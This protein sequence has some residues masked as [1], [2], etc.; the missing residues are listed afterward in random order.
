MLVWIKSMLKVGLIL[1]VHQ[2]IAHQSKTFNLLNKPNNIE[3]VKHNDLS[4]TYDSLNK[5]FIDLTDH[6]KNEKVRNDK[7]ATELSPEPRNALVLLGGSSRGNGLNA[8]AL[9]SRSICPDGFIPRLPS[10]TS[11]SFAAFVEDSIVVCGGRE[12][13]LELNKECWKYNLTIHHPSNDEHEEELKE[14]G[15]WKEWKKS[16]MW[17]AAQ[18]N[19]DQISS[20][21]SPLAGS[22][23]TTFEGKIWVFGGLVEEDYYD[24]KTE[25]EYYYYD[26]VV[27][28]A[29]NG[30][31]LN[32]CKMQF[33]IFN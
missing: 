28:V 29:G 17:K 25:N 27:E 19:W 9:T 10:G 3:N 12:S 1:L 23:V 15:L 32:H 7:L 6:N 31:A 16:F 2:T 13:T 5:S 26:Y 4:S 8:F 14:G 30:I 11:A 20:L 21:P 33:V 24:T 22:A 18:K